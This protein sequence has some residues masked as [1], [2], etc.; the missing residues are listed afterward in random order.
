MN[1]KRTV[2]MGLF[3]GLVGLS[4]ISFAQTITGTATYRERIALPANAVFEATLEDVSRADVPDSTGCIPT[5]SRRDAHQK[6]TC[7]G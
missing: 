5:T 1:R 7:L 3:F 4:P 2:Y 6:L